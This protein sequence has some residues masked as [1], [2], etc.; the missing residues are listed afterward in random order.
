MYTQ[1]YSEVVEHFSYFIGPNAFYVYCHLVLDEKNTIE[2]DGFAGVLSIKKK[3]LRKA[4]KMLFHYSLID[5]HLVNKK[6]EVY[7]FIINSP[8]KFRIPGTIY[9]T[10]EEI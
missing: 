1:F 9:N 5:Y 10:Q 8:D 2:I 7:K 3:H 4:L 6:D